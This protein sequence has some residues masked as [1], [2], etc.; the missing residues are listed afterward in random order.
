VTVAQFRQFLAEKRQEDSGFLKRYPFVSKY[1]ATSALG[2]DEP[3]RWVSWTLA[4]EYCNW[5]SEKE[6]ISREQWCYEIVSPVLPAGAGVMGLASSPHDRYALLGALVPQS[7]PYLVLAEDYLWRKGFRLPTDAEWEVA[8]R[9]GTR[10][11][12]SH[13]SSKALLKEYAWYSQ[14]DDEEQARPVGQLKPNDWGLFDMHGN[15]MEWCLDQ[16]FGPRPG[17]AGGPDLDVGDIDRWV[18]GDQYRVV[19][20]GA[21]DRGASE[22]RSAYVTWRTVAEH[23]HDLGFRLAQTREAGPRPQRKP[24][25]V[26]PGPGSPSEK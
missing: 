18:R 13:G 5:L 9:A 14:K 2:V 17:K 7:P 8:C 12:W 24:P 3:A 15:V 11:A 26:G 23:R 20:G 21:F 1:L 4:A 25:A 16:Q 10:T 6:G 22:T 19:R